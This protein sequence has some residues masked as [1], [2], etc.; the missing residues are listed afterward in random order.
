MKNAGHPG[1]VRSEGSVGK[2]PARIWLKKS[3]SFFLRF[4]SCLGLRLIGNISWSA[5]WT[6]ASGNACRAARTK[7][8]APTSSSSADRRW[9]VRTRRSSRRPPGSTRHIVWLDDDV[10]LTKPEMQRRG[11]FRRQTGP[12]P[13]KVTDHCNGQGV[14]GGGVPFS[15]TVC[16]ECPRDLRP[17]VPLCDGPRNRPRWKPRARLHACA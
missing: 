3:L 5:S 17:D 2:R 15:Q 13:R 1:Q 4:S 16:V 8:A 9:P 12:G 11:R 10:M 7:A 6:R 14:K